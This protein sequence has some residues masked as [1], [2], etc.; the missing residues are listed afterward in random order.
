MICGR[1]SELVK[2]GFETLD[3]AGYQPELAYIECLQ[4]EARLIVKL[5]V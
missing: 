3:E 1:I 4:E 2:E 5:M